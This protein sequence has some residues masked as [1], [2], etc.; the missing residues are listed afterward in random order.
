MDETKDDSN[1]VKCDICKSGIRLEEHA[2]GLVVGNRY[3]A[4]SNCCSTVSKDRLLIW[5]T[6]RMGD[7]NK[8]QSIFRWLWERDN[9]SGQG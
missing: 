4:C 9:Q 7:S 2:T 3:F 6:S 1:D 8:Y 5:S